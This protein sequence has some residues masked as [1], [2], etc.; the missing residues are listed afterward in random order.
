MRGHTRIV[1]VTDHVDLPTGF[2]TQHKVIVKALRTIADAEVVSLGLWDSR[3]AVFEDDFLRVPLGTIDDWKASCKGVLAQQK[4]D[5]LVTLGDMHMYAGVP[6]ALAANDMPCHWVHWYPM[7]SPTFDERW[8]DLFESIDTLVVISRFAQQRLAPILSGRLPMAYIPHGVDLK[9]FKPWSETTKQRARRE[10]SAGS[11]FDLRG[12]FVIFTG[13]TNHWRKNMYVVLDVLK[14]LPDDTVAIMHCPPEPRD[15]S[16]GWDLGEIAEQLGVRDRVFFT[17]KGKSRPE[18]SQA[19][20][21]DLLR[22]S[23]VRVSATQ[24]EGF[25]IWTLEAMACG[26]PSVITDCTTSRE[27]L[28]DGEAGLLTRVAHWQPMQH[29]LLRRA[30]ADVQE[31]TEQARMLYDDPELRRKLGAEGARRAKP[32][33]V[34]R[35]V[36]AWVKLICEVRRRPSWTRRQPLV[37]ESDS[38]S[39]SRKA[40]GRREA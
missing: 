1:T 13:E 25:G 40:E 29:G 2:G 39:S 6:D 7:D 26:I 5:I 8:T 23:D 27:L 28:G 20:L 21:A 31:M 16:N 10:W 4:P 15:G 38:A 14:G 30:F 3:R 11:G 32:Y 12:K 35:V 9:V 36:A 34:Q 18:L 17:G 24:G 22:L 19:N 37:P 33:A